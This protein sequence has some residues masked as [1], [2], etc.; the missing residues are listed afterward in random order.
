MGGNCDTGG[1]NGAYAWVQISSA[2][3]LLQNTATP[4]AAGFGGSALQRGVRGTGQ[5]TFTASEAN[6]PGIAAVTVAIDGHPVYSGSPGSNGGA[7]VPVGTDPASGALMF[8]SEQPCPTTEAVDVPVPTAGLA[9]GAHQL[10]VSVADAAQNSATV[11]DTVIHTSNP[12][13]T[14]A[15]RRGLR[16]QF[17]ISWR[18]LGRR[19]TLRS[20]AVRRLPG[21]ARVSRALC[22]PWVSPAQGLIE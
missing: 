4:L 9:D 17:R 22:R 6:G 15:A 19:T 14:P 2:R 21:N 7:C 13:L 3:L 1:S 20:L 10:A 16:T 8:D 5:L 11:L 18:W 12:E